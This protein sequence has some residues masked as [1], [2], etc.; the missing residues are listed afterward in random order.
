MPAAGHL[1]RLGRWAPRAIEPKRHFQKP[2]A[3]SPLVAIDRERCILCYRC[4]RFS[5]EISGLP[6]RLE[7]VA[8]TATSR[9]STGTYVAPFSGNIIGCARW[10]R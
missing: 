4:V 7:G 6:A 9:P 2:L 5:Q 3:L 10:G 1:L 8:P